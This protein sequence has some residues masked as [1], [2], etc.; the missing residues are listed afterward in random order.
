MIET[1]YIGQGDTLPYYPIVVRDKD[2]VVDLSALGVTAVYFCMKNIA[3]SS[4]VVST[5]ATVTDLGGGEAEYR[6]AVAD[7]G[8]LGDYAASFLFVTP[9][10]SFTLPRSEMAKV[11]VEDKFVTG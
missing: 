6:W 10:G 3:T 7:T 4:V 8:V 2:G 5:L 9:V 1:F 11:V